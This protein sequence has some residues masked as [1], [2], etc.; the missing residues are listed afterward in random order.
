MSAEESTFALKDEGIPQEHA[1]A[2]NDEVE[3]MKTS[4]KPGAQ[5]LMLL[6]HGK[7]TRKASN[8]FLEVCFL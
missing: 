8:Y 2:A 1:D 4:R 5:P 7:Y 3:E 6:P